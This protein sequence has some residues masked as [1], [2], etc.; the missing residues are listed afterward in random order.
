MKRMTSLLKKKKKEIASMACTHRVG[1]K[2]LRLT[3][4]AR[5]L[6]IWGG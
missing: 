3:A 4:A 1:A 5:S 6:Q 2:L